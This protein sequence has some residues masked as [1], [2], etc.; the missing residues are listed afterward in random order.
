MP[1]FDNKNKG[2]FLYN[3]FIEEVYIHIYKQ[4]DID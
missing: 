3:I 1:T 2:Q 4:N